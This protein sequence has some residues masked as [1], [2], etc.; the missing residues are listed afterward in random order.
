MHKFQKGVTIGFLAVIQFPASRDKI[1]RLDSKRNLNRHGEY[2]VNLYFTVSMLSRVKVKP[3]GKTRDHIKFP[4][5]EII[6]YAVE[7]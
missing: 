7:A 3:S 4:G 2:C 1:K 5:T 6:T